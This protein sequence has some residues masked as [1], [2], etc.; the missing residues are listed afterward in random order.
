MPTKEVPAGYEVRWPHKTYDLLK[1]PAAG[2]GPAWIVRC[3]AHGTLTTAEFAR[4]G[5]AVGSAKGRPQWC[6]GCAY[7]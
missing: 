3:N 5:D 7:A 1:R 2:T 4:H 6:S